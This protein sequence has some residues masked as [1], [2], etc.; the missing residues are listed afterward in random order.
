VLPDD[1]ALLLANNPKPA[2]IR[3]AMRQVGGLILAVSRL[4]DAVNDALPNPIAPA[5]PIKLAGLQSELLDRLIEALPEI[6]WLVEAD[7]ARGRGLKLPA[8]Y[9]P[10]IPTR[11][12][13]VAV[14][15]HMDVIGH[16]L[17]EVA[18]HRPEALAAYLGLRVGHPIAA[19]HI[20]R[21]LT[22]PVA[23][24]KA[25]P[26][27]ARVVAVLN[28]RDESAPRPETRQ[29][30]WAALASGRYERVIS[31]SLQ[32]RRPVLEVFTR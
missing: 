24:L 12:T 20:S 30:A 18:A 2:R 1:S 28:Q 22:D 14:L 26:A 3:Q 11:T 25:V 10:V 27:G 23:G 6:M 19:S 32:A 8:A 5:Q 31:A 16:P 7:G 13:L 15:M 17:D 29:A 9:E 21:L 4:P